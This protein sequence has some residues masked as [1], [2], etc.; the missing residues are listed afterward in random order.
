MVGIVLQHLSG[1][2]RFKHLVERNVLLVHLPLGVLRDQDV[3]DPGLGANTVERPAHS[4][5]PVRSS[6]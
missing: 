4:P 2:D 1:A 3:P 5:T 6:T